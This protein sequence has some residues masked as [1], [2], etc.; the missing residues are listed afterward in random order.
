MRFSCDGCGKELRPGEEPRFVVK[1][2][3]FAAQ[4]PAELTEAD[5]EEDHLEAVGELLRELEA[6]AGK[7]DLPEPTRHFRYDLC[8]E[9][10]QKFVRDPLG[11]DCASKV[12]FS[13]N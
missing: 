1:I 5:L 6:G 3:A 9:C 7:L 13:K 2:E 11:K 12:S 10:H 8:E 4:D